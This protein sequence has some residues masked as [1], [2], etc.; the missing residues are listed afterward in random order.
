VIRVDTT[1]ALGDLARFHRS[2][3][4]VP[5][6]A[7]TA[8]AARRRRRRCCASSSAST[9]SRARSY[10]NEIGVPLTLFQMDERTEAA[11]VEVGTNAPGEI[12]HL[13]GSSGP[14]SAS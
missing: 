6:V 8:R 4:D 5:V 3:F 14:R 2:R 12:A 13:A 7:V 9:S 11:V 1:K 10:N